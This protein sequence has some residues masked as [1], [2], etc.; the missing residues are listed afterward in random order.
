MVGGAG[1]A[2][3]AALSV[4]LSPVDSAPVS[5]SL[6]GGG[7]GLLVMYT[8][9][10]TPLRL[11][12]VG[13]VVVSS[14]SLDPDT[15]VVT[16]TPVVGAVVGA[17][18][19]VDGA[20]VN[21]ESAIAVGLS[22]SSLRPPP[23]SSSLLVVACFSAISSSASDAP[24]IVIEMDVD[25]LCVVSSVRV[26]PPSTVDAKFDT[27]VLAVSTASLATSV[28]VSVT[29]LCASSNVIRRRSLSAAQCAT[30]AAIAPNAS[31]ARLLLRAPRRRGLCCEMARR[32]GVDVA[33]TASVPASWWG[34]TDTEGAAW[35]YVVTVPLR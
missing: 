3:G 18:A 6:D 24:P 7:V 26:T 28:I 31:I 8:A 17:G 33:R 9:C 16:D 14:L 13:A 22:F 25:G 27:I 30:T 12:A 29:A 19:R 21:T 1:A 5:S 32:R 10:A 34:S 15:V 2:V 23:P 4:P 20:V 11:V 35:R